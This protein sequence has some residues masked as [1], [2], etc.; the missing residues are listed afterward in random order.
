MDEAWRAR[1]AELVRGLKDWGL[2][3][4]RLSAYRLTPE[5]LRAE[6]TAIT[7]FRPAWIYAYSTSL[8]AFVRANA[9]R[10]EEARRLGLKACIGAAEPMSEDMKAEISEFFR[11]PVGMEYGS[12]EM[13]VC[14]HTHPSFPGYYVYTQHHLLEAIPTAQSGVYDLAV[15]KLFRSAMPLVRYLVG[16]QVIVRDPSFRGGPLKW[17]D[18][19]QGRINDNLRLPDGTEVHSETV[20][21]AVRAESD[22][23]AYQMHQHGPELTLR[24]SLRRGA[25][26][27]GMDERIRGRLVRVHRDFHGLRFQQVEDVQTTSAGKRRWVIREAVPS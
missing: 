1:W 5:I 18:D 3:Y 23:V 26:L 11:C 10:R 14:A 17:F 27:S 6:F 25:N 8:L 20:T 2:G 12:V 4:R 21:H 13:R 22:V 16:D 7:R 19:V 15:T 9:D 24:L